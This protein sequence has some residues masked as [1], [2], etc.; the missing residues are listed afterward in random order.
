MSKTSAASIALSQRSTGTLESVELRPVNEVLLD[1]RAIERFRSRYREEFGAVG[2][3]TIRFMNRSAPDGASA[4]MEH[5]LPLYYESLETIFDYL[6]GAAV[7]L[8]HAG[9]G[10]A[11]RTGSKRSPI[12]TPRQARPTPAPG[13]PVYRAAAAGTA[14]S[15]RVANGRRRW[16]R[17]ASA[18]LSPFAAPEGARG[19][20]CRAR[21]RALILPPRAPIPASIC[22][23]RV[24]ARIDAER[25][26]P[27]AHVLIAAYSAG[28]ADRLKS[29][30]QRS[31]HGGTR[32]RGGIG[33]RFRGAAAS[34]RRA[35]PCCRSSTA[36]Q[37]GRGRAHH[38]A[39]HSR[40]PSGAAA[41]AARQARSVHR[42]GLRD[43]RRRP[44]RASEHGIGRYDGLDTLDVAGAPHDCLRLIYDGDDKLFLPVEN[45]EVLS[46]Y[47][48]ED[49]G[50][51]ARQ[52]GR[53]RLAVAQ[54]ADEGRIRD[55]AAE[56]IHIAAERQIRDAEIMA[57]PEGI[58]DEFCARFPFPRPKTRP[59]HRRRAGR[60][61]VGPADGPADLRRC[62]LRQDRGGV[63][64]RLRRRHGGRRRSRWWCRRRCW[65]ASI[66]APSPSASPACRSRSRSSRAWC[67]AQARRE[68]KTRPGRRPRQ[69]RHRHPRAA[70]E[71]HHLPPSRAAGGRRGAAFRRGAEGAAEAAQ[72]RCACADAD[73]DADPAHACSWRWPACAR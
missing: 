29:V 16:T 42:R 17:A 73:R 40:R 13:A 66:S 41:A 31:R 52:A 22:S 58:Y 45:I 20:R 3:R 36:M 39:G 44:G 1:E 7:S 47:G 28:S 9:R 33:R 37:R 14:L 64:R 50:V 67:R 65:R 57:P 35:W 54:G 24:R 2:C 34:P 32:A 30:L 19:V 69:H 6:P 48:S 60:P 72:G 51:R 23:M 38:R 61:A 53:R 56:L 63:A 55:M 68:V 15:R 43:R 11:A 18:Q 4:G 59:R 49:A 25:E 5:W 62:R 21:C 46:R 71:E 26:M 12:S 10:G 70:G 27:A 8:D